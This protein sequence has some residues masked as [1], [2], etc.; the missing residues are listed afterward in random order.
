MTEL[1]R[2]AETQR[3]LFNMKPE[4]KVVVADKFDYEKA[5]LMSTITRY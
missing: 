4:K 1:L 5:D 3:G 2:D